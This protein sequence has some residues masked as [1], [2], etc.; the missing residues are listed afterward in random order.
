MGNQEEKDT[1]IVPNEEEIVKEA[2]VEGGFDVAEDD[3][4]EQ[5]IEEEV[6]EEA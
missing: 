5:P 4:N 2:P 3:I 1:N 6:K